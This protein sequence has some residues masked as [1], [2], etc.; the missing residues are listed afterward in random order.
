MVQ[1]DR[2]P[3]M[4]APEATSVATFS[5]G[6]HSQYTSSLYWGRFSR[7]YVLGVPG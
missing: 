6:A 7:I 2:E 1:K 4:D 5:V 3:A